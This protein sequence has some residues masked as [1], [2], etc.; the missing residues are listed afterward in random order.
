[1]RGLGTRPKEVVLAGAQL[2]GGLGVLLT[3]WV[4]LA[5][6][7]LEEGAGVKLKRGG[8]ALI[9][10]G[11]RVW[12]GGGECQP[13]S[14]V[15]PLVV[16]LYSDTIGV[17]KPPSQTEHEASFSVGKAGCFGGL[18]SAL[19]GMCWALVGMYWALVGMCWALVGM[20]WGSGELELGSIAQV[21]C[22]LGALRRCFH[23]HARTYTCNH[24]Q[25]HT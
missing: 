2:S 22:S 1:M 21:C 4:G 25:S 18:G 14:T 19:V 7:Q 12:A 15:T 8:W 16:N 20:C 23:A 13:L 17:E 3:K 5:G 24:T 10:R 6:A 9:K 11:L